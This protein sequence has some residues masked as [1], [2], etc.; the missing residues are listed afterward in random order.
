MDCLESKVWLG[1]NIHGTTLVSQGTCKGN[2]DTICISIVMVHL[3]LSIS[4]TLHYHT[5]FG[6][7]TSNK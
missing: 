5:T 4:N 1:E 3:V 7:N 6:S 2:C